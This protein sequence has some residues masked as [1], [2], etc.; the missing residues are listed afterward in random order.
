MARSN[1]DPSRHQRHLGRAKA[2][3]KLVELKAIRDKAR[4]LAWRYWQ[5][6][7]GL[8]G[9][10]EGQDTFRRHVRACI[11][12]FDKGAQGAGSGNAN[13]GQ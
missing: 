6:L 12:E 11:Q 9:G 1:W 7:Q 10:Q 8:P 13:S 5:E 4:R 2:G 3:L